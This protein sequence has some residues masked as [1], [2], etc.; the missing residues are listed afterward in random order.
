MLSLEIL[1]IAAVNYFLSSPEIY[2]PS[3]IQQNQVKNLLAQMYASFSLAAE[4]LLQSMPSEMIQNQQ[5]NY[6]KLNQVLQQRKKQRR[7]ELQ[8]TIKQGNE[9]ITQTLK[10]L[11]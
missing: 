1:S 11:T 4:L 5:A 8:T 7:K 9:M 10:G 6:N 2:K 3:Q